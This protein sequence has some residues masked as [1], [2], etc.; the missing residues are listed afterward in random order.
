MAEHKIFTKEEL[1]F[2]TRLFENN[3]CVST[4]PDGTE[5]KC[6]HWSWDIKGSDGEQGDCSTTVS[7]QLCRA[8]QI[9]ALNEYRIVLREVK[10]EDLKLERQQK[11]TQIQSK[12]ISIN[13]QIR[14]LQ[15]DKEKLQVKVNSQKRMGGIIDGNSEGD[16]ASS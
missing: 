2:L 13:Q 6:P 9:G 5:L 4:L 11:T 3:G 14:E 16:P 8:L 1:Q 7:N 10:P 15:K 12:I